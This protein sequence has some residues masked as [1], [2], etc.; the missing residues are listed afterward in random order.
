MREAVQPLVSRRAA[1]YI[2]TTQNRVADRAITPCRSPAVPDTGW[3][4]PASLP[5][6]RDG[7]SVS[8]SAAPQ[9][10]TALA[11]SLFAIAQLR[12]EMLSDGETAFPLERANLPADLLAQM[13]QCNHKL[14]AMIGNNLPTKS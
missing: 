6:I 11:D 10:H 12:I 2:L 8:Q 4:L 1:T 5:G 3:I 7:C 9:D 13:R 14:A